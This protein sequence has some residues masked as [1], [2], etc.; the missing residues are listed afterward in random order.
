MTLSLSTINTRSSHQT[1]S[2]IMTNIILSITIWN[3]PIAKYRM[4][5]QPNTCY[6]MPPSTAIQYVLWLACTAN[7]A[8]PFYILLPDS[9]HPP[10]RR[11]VPLIHV[12]LTKLLAL[13]PSLALQFEINPLYSSI[14]RLTDSRLIPV[15]DLDWT[16]VLLYIMLW[17][18]CA[19][20]CSI[21]PNPL[22]CWLHLLILSV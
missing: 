18:V 15:T 3:Q 16:T 2:T 6:S 5:N 17:L 22:N 21:F 8:L 20:N 12:P 11:I 7:C 4:T 9:L 14:K 1:T 13:L 19:T 10:L